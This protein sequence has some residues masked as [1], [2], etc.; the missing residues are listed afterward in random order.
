VPRFPSRHFFLVKMIK[1]ILFLLFIPNFFYSSNCFSQGSRKIWDLKII[2]AKKKNPIS[3]ATVS[4][5]QKVYFPADSD[6]VLKLDLAKNALKTGDS[7]LFSAVGYVSKRIVIDL[8]SALPSIVELS[9]DV[10][11]LKE[12]KVSFGKHEEV[13]IGKKGLFITWGFLIHSGFTYAQFMPNLNKMSGYVK[14]IQ[15]NLSNA[16]HDIKGPF[17]VRVYSKSDASMY[18]ASELIHDDLIIQNPGGGKSVDVDISKYNIDFPPNG[19]FIVINLLPAEYYSD[20][21]FFKYGNYREE[22][23]SFTS[24]DSKS[25]AEGYSSDMGP[26]LVWHVMDHNSFLI[27]LKIIKD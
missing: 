1:S 22:L 19:I 11:N 16:G 26:N 6:G 17:R 23:P 10:I 25:Q 5:N 7:V 20:R 3:Y 21:T 14:A 13:T 9:P 8:N 4:I 18:P 15:F 27:R 24:Y 2:D 12:V